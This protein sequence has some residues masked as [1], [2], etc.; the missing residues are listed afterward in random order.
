MRER[1]TN[2]MANA[3]LANVEASSSYQQRSTTR[4]LASAIS[5]LLVA[6]FL[7][8]FNDNFF[9]IVLSMFA[10]NAAGDAGGALSL[11]GAIFIFPFLLFS[12]Y[13]G[14]V[15][16]VYSKRTVLISTKVLEIVTM[17]VG[18]VA[19]LS[20]QF[21]FLLVVLFLLALQATFFS[22]AKYSILPELVETKDLSRA[23]GLLEMSN[24][25]AIILG[26]SLGSIL[27][28]TWKD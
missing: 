2:P 13:A 4:P 28:A 12:G 15:S 6:Q 20:G 23:N 27:F 24:F 22:P 17:S 16:D 7:G 26:T 3:Q 19:F 5:G 9:K 25:L 14:H 1:G 18:F 10:V 21:S 11:I 8:S